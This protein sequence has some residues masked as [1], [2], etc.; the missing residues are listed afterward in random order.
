MP[1][2]V[3]MMGSSPTRRACAV[4]L[5]LWLGLLGACSGASPEGRTPVRLN[6]L[7][8]SAKETDAGVLVDRDTTTM[9]SLT[10]PVELLLRFPHEVELRAF[11]L[12]GGHQLQVVIG[13]S[14]PVM[15]DR[16]DEWWSQPLDEMLKTT[17][18][19]VRLIPTGPEAR[20]AELEVWG[21]G[22][23]AA[24]REP[25]LLAEA[26]R[27]HLSLPFENALAVQAN[28]P[29]FTLHPVG[30]GTGE[31][32]GRTRIMAPEV[33]L[34]AV[35]RAHL[36]Y[37]ANGVQRAFVLQ[38]SI[39]GRAPVGGL[40]LGGGSRVHTVADE[41]DPELLTGNDG[42]TLCLP[43]EAVQS[44]QVSNL[45]LLLEFDDGTNTIDRDAQARLGAAFDG[46]MRTAA[47]LPRGRVSLSFARSMVL[48]RMGLRPEASPHLSKQA[49]RGLAGL[50]V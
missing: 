42:I 13:E 11:K 8:S 2:G 38:R 22:R 33:P 26:T 4:A 6:P 35:R 20:L 36:A 30:E 47:L 3:S 21:L 49:R 27:N 32:C 1:G 18:V 14:R 45:R 5:V 17:S 46:D 43:A 25:R 39:N 31:N 23:P 15:M 34:R 24:P 9:L 10:S 44:V 41:L 19:R 16:P 29:S 28:P 7:V 50:L 12:H 40:W 37:E 48:D